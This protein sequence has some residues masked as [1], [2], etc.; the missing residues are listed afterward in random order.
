MVAVPFDIRIDIAGGVHRVAVVGELDVATGPI[1]AAR[2]REAAAGASPAVVVDLSGVSFIDARGLR[3]L[4]GA[5]ERLG[6]G[7]RPRL[8]FV[9]PSPAVR[10][11]VALA[12]GLGHSV[13]LPD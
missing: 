10:R 3:V 2:L 11:C 8:R 7:D 13:P 4:V 5:H 9:N 12:R 6:A 1:L